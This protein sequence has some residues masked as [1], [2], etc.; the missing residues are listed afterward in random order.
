MV[1]QHHVF[2]T[3]DHRL[4]PASQERGDIGARMTGYRGDLGCVEVDG[5]LGE[6]LL[7]TCI[8]LYDIPLT[9]D[10]I[11]FD[12]PAGQEA[13]PLQDRLLRPLVDLDRPEVGVVEDPALPLAEPLGRMDIR[14]QILLEMIKSSVKEIMLH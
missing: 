9:E 13:L 8:D 5:G 14:A 3:E 1:Q 12:H 10:S 6:R 7:P 11:A 2:G 4:M